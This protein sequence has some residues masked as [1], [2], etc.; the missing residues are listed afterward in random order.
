GARPSRTGT[1]CACSP[2]VR[3]P[4]IRPPEPCHAAVELTARLRRKVP[5]VSTWE[6]DAIEGR[7]DSGAGEGPAPSAP[8]ILRSPV[9]GFFAAPHLDDGLGRGLPGW[10]GC[11]PGWFRGA[12]RSR[13][14]ERRGGQQ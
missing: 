7:G 6:P 1:P 10:V 14:G 8:V 2:P 11:N 4:R 13:P 3:W 9:S 12:T 5:A